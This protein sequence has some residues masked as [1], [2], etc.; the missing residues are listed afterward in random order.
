MFP[1]YMILTEFCE[2]LKVVS[3]NFSDIKNIVAPL[4]SSSLPIKLF[5]YFKLGFSNWICLLKSIATRLQCFE[6]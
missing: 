2:K 6:K 3:S 4:S 5:C 1:F